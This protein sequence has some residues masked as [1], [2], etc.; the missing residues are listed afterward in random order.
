MRLGL[1]RDTC[2]RQAGHRVVSNDDI[3][4]LNK[5][6]PDRFPI[7]IAGINGTNL[8]AALDEIK[9]VMQKYGSTGI[10]E[11][12]NKVVFEIMQYIAVFPASSTKLT[13]SKGNVLPD[14][15]LMPSGSTALDFAFKIHTDLGNKFIK[16]IDVKRKMPIGKEHLLKNYD[17]IEIVTAK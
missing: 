13:D 10:Q 1:I 11:T 3:A 9:K 17:V 4:E 7:A 6:Y 5:L 16:A 14:C 8:E 12:L 2:G 15:F